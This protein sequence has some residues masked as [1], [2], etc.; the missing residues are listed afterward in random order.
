MKHIDIIQNTQ[1]DI[2]ITII[3]IKCIRKDSSIL[4]IREID[5]KGIILKKILIGIIIFK[6]IIR[7]NMNTINMNIKNPNINKNLL[8][9]NIKMKDHNHRIVEILN[10]TVILNLFTFYKILPYILITMIVKA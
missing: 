6:N 7:T 8:K 9:S 10:N 5:L 1:K 4:I 2:I 3:I